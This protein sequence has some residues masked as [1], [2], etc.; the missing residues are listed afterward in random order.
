MEAE[1]G[2]ALGSM[3][4]PP[5]D[6]VTP[7]GKPSAAA[8]GVRAEPLLVFVH[9]PKAAGK[10]L[11]KILHRHYGDDFVGGGGEDRQAPLGM[12]AAPNVFSRLD[13][14]DAQLRSIASMSN[15]RAIAGHITFGLHDR[16]P[17][18]ARYITL[19]REP[20]ERTL[21][22]YFFFVQPPGK[23]AGR[24]GK[25]FVPPWLPQPSPD[26][27]LDESL[28]ERGYIPDNLQTR[29]LCGLVSPYDPL[30]PDALERA[31]LN[32]RERFAFVGTT[33]RF[34]EFLALLNLDLEWPTVACKPANVNRHRPRKRDIPPNVV[35]L[36]EE[37]NTLDRELHAYAEELLTERLAHA[38]PELDLEIEVLKHAARSGSRALDRSWPIDV[39]VA[40]ALAEAELAEAQLRIKRLNSRLKW[41]TRRPRGGE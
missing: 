1:E 13:Q 30:P 28:T 7:E 37:R 25:G 33:E 41:R 10:T 21:S 14:V 40:L 22:H 4:Q 12:R 11:A 29:M 15:V 17:V 23:R 6:V 31:K 32:L 16:L 19:L 26:L 27:T 24:A 38:G 8:P 36:V 34:A 3:S 35:R 18:N 5:L 20:V 39:R 2:R 9:I